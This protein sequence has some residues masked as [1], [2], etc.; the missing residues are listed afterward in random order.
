MSGVYMLPSIL[1]QLIAAVLAGRLVGKVGRYL[2]FALV[3]AALMSLGYGLCSTFSPHTST[4]EWIGYQILFGAGRGMGFQ[5]PIVAVQHMLPPA[6]APLAISLIMFTGMIFGALF[7]SFG[8]TIFTQSLRQLIP[9]QDPGV[10]A[11]AIVQ[12]GATGFRKILEPSE[13]GGILAAYSK[14]IDRVFYMVTAL[15]AVSFFFAFGLGWKDIREKKAPGQVAAAEKKV[16]EE[17]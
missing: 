9:Q 1:S 17:A 2:P 3:S 13:I 6:Q 4:G 8:A 12:A 16:S 5:M 10:D 14:S 15:T 7:L 11:G